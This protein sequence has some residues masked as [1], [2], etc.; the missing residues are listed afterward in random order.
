MA[1]NR[2]EE[3]KASAFEKEVKHLA[4][5][6]RMVKSPDEDV[7]KYMVFLLEIR[8]LLDG[9]KEAMI[10]IEEE[11]AKVEFGDLLE[12]VIAQKLPIPW[13]IYPELSKVKAIREEAVQAKP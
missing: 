13:S 8:F 5:L 9:N 11:N 12:Y 10:S 1:V 3:I 4:G 7:L 6:V 2:Y